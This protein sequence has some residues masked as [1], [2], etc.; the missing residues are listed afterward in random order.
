[1]KKFLLGLLGFFMM[2]GM[3]NAQTMNIEDITVQSDPR[4]EALI[5]LHLDYND[6][7]PNMPGYRIQIFMESGNEAL[8]NAKKVKEKFNEKYSDIPAYILFVAPYYRVRIGDFRTRLE[9]EKALQRI[10]NKY[11]N[12]W[13][14][15]DVINFPEI[16]NNQNN[17]SY[18]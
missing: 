5:Q 12:A 8:T 7:Y 14:I 9:G 6:L 16:V 15:K 17:N 10:S 11:P 3:A 1:M 2:M 4:I 13:I 18:E